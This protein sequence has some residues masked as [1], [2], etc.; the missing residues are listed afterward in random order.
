MA[1]DNLVYFLFCGYSFEFVLVLYI[2][3]L[4]CTGGPTWTHMFIRTPMDTRACTN[5]HHTHTYTHTHIHTHTHTHTH[6]R[7]RARAQADTPHTVLLSPPPLFACV[8][9]YCGK[10]VVTLVV[11]DRYGTSKQWFRRTCTQIWICTQPHA[12]YSAL[13][14]ASDVRYGRSRCKIVA[15]SVTSD[16]WNSNPGVTQ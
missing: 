11:W 5:T 3:T 7:A 16:M 10:Q 13:N 1:T 8:W 15:Q 9:R 4:A 6:A 2:H 14:G 12:T